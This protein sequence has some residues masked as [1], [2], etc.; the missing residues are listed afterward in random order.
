MPRP[1]LLTPLFCLVARAMQH[2]TEQGA[3]FQVF[4]QG[5]MLLTGAIRLKKGIK[6]DC[7]LRGM[8]L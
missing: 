3:A 6:L 1:G 4:F 2:L 8:L 7:E 5:S